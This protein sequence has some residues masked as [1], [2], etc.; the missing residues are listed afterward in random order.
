M[1]KPE[2]TG[3]EPKKIEEAKDAKRVV[4]KVQTLP[5]GCQQTFYSDGTAEEVP[6]I[7][8][9]LYKAGQSLANAA[10]A[11]AYAGQKMLETKMRGQQAIHQAAVTAI[12]DEQKKGKK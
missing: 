11:I 7:A 12:M 8:H 4:E 3:P 2:T 9:A 6:C 1:E 10:Q 5:C